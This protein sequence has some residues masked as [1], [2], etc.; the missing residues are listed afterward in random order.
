MTA[1]IYF[2]IHTLER[3]E[4]KKVSKLNKNKMIEASEK[5]INA[6]FRTIHSEYS[7]TRLVG[8]AFP[9]IKFIEDYPQM[10]TDHEFISQVRGVPPQLGKQGS[11]V[12]KQLCWCKTK[13]MLVLKL[14]LISRPV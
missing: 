3:D 11:A 10:N 12:N 4:E 2:G 9:T 5:Q 1:M 6:S 13:K 7:Q 14:G 8:G